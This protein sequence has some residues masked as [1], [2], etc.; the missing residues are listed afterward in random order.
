MKK[1]ELKKPF[2]LWFTG[3]PS[4]GKTT[5]AKAVKDKLLE[6]SINIIHLDGDTLRKGLNSD[7]GFSKKD[8]KE[9]NRRVIYLSK[10]IVENKIP[11]VVS[12][13]S[14]YESI[15]VKAKEIIPNIIQVFIDCPIEEC[16]KRDVK[17]LYRKAKMGEIKGMTGIDDPFET[18]GTSDV[19]INTLEKNIEQSTRILMD[20]LVSLEY[21]N[22]VA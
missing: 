16:I 14:P 6:S 22:V 2:C 1:Y 20:Y 10:L 5:L 13:I 12:F 17:G 21:L 19:K 4:S 15:R 8:R 7:L 9:N 18:P 11:V 3:L